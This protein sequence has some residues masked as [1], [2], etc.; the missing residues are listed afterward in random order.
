MALK[1]LFSTADNAPATGRA[2]VDKKFIV[3]GDVTMLTLQSS[4]AIRAPVIRLLSRRRR[5]KRHAVA[6]RFRLDRPQARRL[7][8]RRHGS[9]DGGVLDAHFLD[10]EDA[11]MTKEN[12]VKVLAFITYPRDNRS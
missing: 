10:L 7:P 4:A 1:P 5:R 2:L 3:T 9:S 11:G 6:S 8:G 12:I